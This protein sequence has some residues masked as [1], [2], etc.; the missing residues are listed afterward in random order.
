MY[1]P[2][3]NNYFI[4]YQTRLYPQFLLFVSP[5]RAKGLIHSSNLLQAMSLELQAICI[6]RYLLPWLVSN[7]Q[8]EVSEVGVSPT[9]C[10]MKGGV[11]KK[12]EIV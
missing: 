10:K 11:C 5:H 12:Q 8:G 2:S 7:L 3:G 6:K 9:S 4:I 1:P